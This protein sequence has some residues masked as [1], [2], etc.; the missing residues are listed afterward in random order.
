MSAT[1]V[2]SVHLLVPRLSMS[3]RPFLSTVVLI[4]VMAIGADAVSQQPGVGNVVASR[5]MPPGLLSALG[6][7]RGTLQSLTLPPV[8]HSASGFPT[9]IDQLVFEVEL[10][11][12][13]HV[14]EL[15]SAEV[16]APG[17]RL[18]RRDP[19][20]LTEVPMGPCT[21]FRGGLRGD[22]RSRVAASY[23]DGWLRAVLVHNDTLWVVQPLRDAVPGAAATTYA[24]FRGPDCLPNASHCGVPTTVQPTPT[25]V[26][27]DSV[28]E[29]ELALQ[30]DHP[31]FLLNTSSLS[32]TQAEVLGIVNA[33]DLIFQGS[34]TVAFQVSQLIVDTAPDP[35]TS[36]NA[37]TLLS[38][39]RSFWNANYLSVGRDVAHLFT[40]RQVGTSSAGV[41]GLAYTAT[42]C[43]VTNAYAL[44]ETR[45]SPN[46]ALRVGLT[47]HEFGHNFGATHCDAL[48][49]CNLMCSG[50]G[51]CT[52]VVSTFGPAAISEMDTYLQTVSCLALVPTVPQ[53]SSASPVLL[54]TVGP[55]EV[56]LGGTGFLG[57]TSVTLGGQPLVGSFQVLSDVLMRISPPVGLS[58]GVYPL[59]V[60]N[61]AGTSNAV[62]LIYQGADPCRIVAPL[63]VQGGSP[64]TWRVGGWQG[65]TGYLGVSL[66]DTVAPL[67]GF[68]VLTEFLTL[69]AGPLDARGMASVTVPSVPSALAGFP[70]YSQM[71]DEVT[72][73]GTIRS[74]SLVLRTLIY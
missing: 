70:F 26:F 54:E 25:G 10:E 60:T 56:T 51:G 66:V 29:C 36:A 72:G 65:G 33:V 38:E 12:R 68:P 18:L 27:G 34:L 13:M 45:W 58:L 57:T 39:F 19:M 63:V 11:G 43:D 22:V 6:I 5:Q 64:Y 23:A 71:V 30:A 14:V 69:W 49:N 17:Y 53:I 9:A 40:G 3:L 31:L 47:A 50:I 35:Y 4:A 2:G 62:F 16:R 74:S 41:V 21:T 15:H 59:Q 32:A 20:G 55:P 24:V 67:Q 44:S 1:M 7:H 8:G 61:P 48:G 46:F 52:G 37:T 42:A 73:T 28:Y